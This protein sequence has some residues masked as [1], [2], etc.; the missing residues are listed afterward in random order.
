[1]VMFIMR[2]PFTLRGCLSAQWRMP[3]LSRADLS[4]LLR[5]G[6]RD[7][8]RSARSRSAGR[9]G[10][11]GLTVRAAT[12][13]PAAPMRHSRRCGSVRSAGRG[14]A[15][16][17]TAAAMPERTPVHAPCG[18]ARK[19][20]RL[21]STLKRI[22]GPKRTALSRRRYEP[23]AMTKAGKSSFRGTENS[24]QGSLGWVPVATGGNNPRK[25]TGARW[26]CGQSSETSSFAASASIDL[27]MSGRRARPS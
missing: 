11:C 10:C 20:G 16:V 9:V 8:H 26:P 17:A 14:M 22:R 12:T 3:C 23:A 4:R 6:S 19:A 5:T 27:R 25:I 2:L 15:T 21:A 1:M 24:R 7:V 18:C 13:H